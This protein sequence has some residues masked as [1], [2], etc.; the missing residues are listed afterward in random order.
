MRARDVRA[1]SFCAV[2][3]V[4]LAAGSGFLLHSP[5]AALAL[6]A[7]WEAFVLTRPRMLRVFRRLRGDPDWSGY[8][9]NSG[10]R[11]TPRPGPGTTPPGPHPA[12]RP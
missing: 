12:E 11:L 8:F 6:T 3:G 10:T 4:V 5:I 9:D 7:A 1:I 2:T